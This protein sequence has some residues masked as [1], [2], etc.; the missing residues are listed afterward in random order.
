MTIFQF[1]GTYLVQIWRFLRIPF[2]A[3]NVPIAA[4]IIFPVFATVV[5]RFIKN[6][7]TGVSSGS[8]KSKEE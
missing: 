3:T 6:V 2:P 8:S 1:L 4:I 5:L 7:L